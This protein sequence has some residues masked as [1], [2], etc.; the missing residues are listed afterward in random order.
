MPVSFCSSIEQLTEAPE[1]IDWYGKLQPLGLQYGPSFKTLHHVYRTDSNSISAQIALNSTRGMMVQ[2]SQYA[3]H[4]ATLDGCLQ[5]AFIATQNRAIASPSRVFLPSRITSMTISTPSH[6]QDDF[7]IVRGHGAIR[8]LR[9][10]ST[11]FALI[12]SG[13]ETIVDANVIFLSVEGGFA[14]VEELHPQPYQR[15]CWTPRQDILDGSK[16]ED[17][18]FAESDRANE[19]IVDA[20][21]TF[22]TGLNH[23]LWLIH[24]EGSPQKSLQRLISS[25]HP[26]SRSAMVSDLSSV[27]RGASVVLLAQ[28]DMTNMDEHM[29]RDMQIVFQ[30]A[31]HVIWTTCSDDPA[32]FIMHGMMKVLETEYPNLSVFCVDIQD[33]ERDM[34]VAA[35]VILRIL[36]KASSGLPVIDKHI[37]IRAGEPHTCQYVLDEDANANDQSFHQVMT[38]EGKYEPGL[39]LDMRRVGKSESAFFKR[40]SFAVSQSHSTANVLI[41]PSL[42]GMTQ[43]EARSLLGKEF[44]TSLSR[45]SL[46]D[47]VRVTGHSALKVGQQVFCLASGCFDS[48]LEVPEA[49]CV[50]AGPDSSAVGQLAAY[51]IAVQALV[52]TAR[53][54]ERDRVLIHCGSDLLTVVAAQI[55]QQAG[56]KVSY[57]PNGAH[58]RS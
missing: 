12:S 14:S 9:Q 42:Y 30:R 19:M 43:R 31:S 22:T 2:E 58:S 28:L 40:S 41:R 8:G 1:E 23:P 18:S 53:V 21:H 6:D 11:K 38:T 36:D 54:R 17:K 29:L 52:N 7:A 4:P 15:M 33:S 5:A 35:S 57:M 26:F 32:M 51:C 16:A 56:A 27:P 24:D 13:G 20:Q 44:S 47:V 25:L 39:A 10:T 55:A 34:R 45:E 50:P 3:V 48:E 49:H 37:F 46:G